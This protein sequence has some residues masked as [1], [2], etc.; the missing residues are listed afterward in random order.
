MA[1][2]QGFGIPEK[3]DVDAP[4]KSSNCPKNAWTEITKQGLRDS[5]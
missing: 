5:D 3:I 1:C 4:H 2:A